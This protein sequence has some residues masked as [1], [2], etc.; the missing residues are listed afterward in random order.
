MC[1]VTYDLAASH[2]AFINLLTVISRYGWLSP[3]EPAIMVLLL[4]GIL[5]CE[6]FS[7]IA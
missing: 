4:L 3:T 6:T 1:Y 7:M 2:N 5:F